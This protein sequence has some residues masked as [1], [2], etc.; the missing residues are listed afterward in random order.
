MVVSLRPLSILLVQFQ[1]P[2]RHLRLAKPPG[3]LSN[4]D[5]LDSGQ[6]WLNVTTTDSFGRVVVDVYTYYVDSEVTSTP[7]LSAIGNHIV[8]NG[9]NYLGPGSSISITNLLD[10][11][12]IGA[13]HFSCDDGGP[14]QTYPSATNVSPPSVVGMTTAFSLTCNIVDLLGNVGP[15]VTYSG[16]T[17][18]SAPT[19]SII[20]PGGV[21]IT[22]QTNLT[23]TSSD[24]IL[25]G[26]SSAMIFWDDGF[27]SWNTSISFNG[28]WVGSLSSLNSSLGD[29]TVS[30]SVT[31]QDWF[32]NSHTSS[33]NSLSLNT[34]IVSTQ[35]NLNL[36]RP[37]VNIG[38]WVGDSIY[39]TA[40]PP[41]GGSF[42]STF[43]HSLGTISG[44]HTT[45]QTGQTS[46]GFPS[47]GDSLDSGQVWLNV[48]T[49]DSFGR[50][51]V[52]VYT[53]YVDSEVTS[54]P[55]L[56]AIG[57]H[58]VLNGSNYL[59]PGSSISITNLLDSGGIGASHFS[60]DDGGP[61][62]TYPSATN[63]SPPSVVGM[64]TA[65]SLTCNIVDLLGNVGPSVT[66]S[67]FTDLSA[68]TVSIIP[69]G[70]VTITPQTNLTFTSSDD[71]LNGTSSAMI[72]WDD[73]FDSWNTSISFNGSWVGSLSSL[74]S[75]LGDG[76]VSISVT[77]QDWFGNSH[78]SSVNS[79]SLNTSIVSTQVNLNLSRPMVN[80]GSWVGDSIYFTSSYTSARW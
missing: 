73:G 27:D 40:T 30:I 29:G 71:I 48:T 3:V 50:V 4:G 17:D 12:G 24:D 9:S 58:I 67:G 61:L 41:Q 52:D 56:S 6:V 60:C 44:S 25:N 18:L 28:S 35:V 38:S 72:F 78:T 39:F 19:V 42:T 15:S 75:S 46:W 21:T 22:P 45:P 74:N 62:Q 16:F 65:F 59:G 69:P 68:P 8:L 80:I 34:S 10:S 20:P 47:N 43:E 51:V 2:T 66:Y 37:M 23:F 36:S 64:T 79:L 77:G 11:G 55:I 33:V 7:I 31:G 53:Y 63:V 13:S 14:L 26:T 54:T 76:T 57:N 49:T 32:G 1:V 70:G 5:S